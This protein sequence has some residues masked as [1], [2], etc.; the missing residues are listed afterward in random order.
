MD[1]FDNRIA[2][3]VRT[4]HGCFCHNH[5]PEV[6]RLIDDLVKQYSQSDIEYR[7]HE[8]GPEIIA[9]LAMGTAGMVLTTALV[10]LITAI[11]NACKA[12]SKKGDRQN[13][14]LIL[15]VRDVRRSE[16]S[17]EEV[18]LELYEN[19]TVSADT[20]KKVIEASIIKKNN[21][22]GGKNK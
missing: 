18:V 2:I 12:G 6:N 9:W 20:V 4:E 8:S 15:I 1:N 5:S 3:K 7:H 22:R 17:E 10:N 13:G 21:K 11:V 14:K 19:D 16:T